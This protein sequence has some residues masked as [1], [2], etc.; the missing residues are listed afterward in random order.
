MVMKAQ[1][2]TLAGTVFRQPGKP[3]AI[4]GK[5]RFR[6]YRFVGQGLVLTVLHGS[7]GFTINQYRGIERC[8][9]L[10]LG[11]DPFQLVSK[12]IVEQ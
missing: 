1:R 10:E 12:I 9:K 4:G 2:H 3:L 5:F 8:V 7:P 11:F 6:Q